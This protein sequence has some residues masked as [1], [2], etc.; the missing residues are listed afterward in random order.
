MNINH[1]FKKNAEG[2]WVMKD[3]SVNIPNIHNLK[4]AM[5]QF[6]KMQQAIKQMEENR[7][8][9]VEEYRTPAKPAGCPDGFEVE[10][11]FNPEDLI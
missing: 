11:S 3:E 10:A 9:L 4:Y 8:D 5:N 1:V 6:Q 7:K 2:E